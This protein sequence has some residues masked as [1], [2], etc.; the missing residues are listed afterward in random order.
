MV[1]LSGAHPGHRCV[2]I[3]IDSQGVQ[4]QW[5]GTSNADDWSKNL[6]RARCE[7]SGNVG[8]FA[9]GRGEVRP[10][11]LT[12]RLSVAWVPFHAGPPQA[13]QDAVR[14]RS[15]ELDASTETGEAAAAAW[16]R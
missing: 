6:I 4:I 12:D 7:M 5:S 10:D 1:S 13:P 2:S 11:C 16:L 9:A 3:D 15:E 8:L 14:K